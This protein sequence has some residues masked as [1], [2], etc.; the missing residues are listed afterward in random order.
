MTSIIFSQAQHKIKNNDIAAA[1][2][3]WCTA[4]QWPCCAMSTWVAIV[5]P[6]VLLLLI[7]VIGITIGV[8]QSQSQCA[9][10]GVI[11]FFL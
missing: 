6:L 3:Q 9:T 4:C 1:G 8:L 2:R 10:P 7:S 5:L 11:I